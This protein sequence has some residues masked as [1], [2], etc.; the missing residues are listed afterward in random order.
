MRLDTLRSRSTPEGVELVLRTA[1]PHARLVAWLLDAAVQAVGYGTIATL[2]SILGR[3]GMG[4]NSLVL[5]LVTWFYPVVCEVF[6]RGQT[7]GKRQLRLKVVHVDGT[8]IGLTA[9]LIR[10][11]VRFADFFPACYG[12]GLTCCL[13]NADFRRLGDLAA[14]TLVVHLETGALGASVPDAPPVPPPL[15]LELPEQRAVIGFGERAEGWTAERR[16]ELAEILQP[17][18][19]LQGSWAVTRLLGH[20]A[21]LVGRR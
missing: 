3:T 5:F 4:L 1:G 18:T 21:W 16:V 9:S 14:G 12:A 7:I 17:V 6:F 2:L 15:P 20:A 13:M 8:P 11:L 10:N 19:R